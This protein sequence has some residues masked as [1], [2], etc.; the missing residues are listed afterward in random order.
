MTRAE[1]QQRFHA[2]KAL[3]WQFTHEMIL[4]TLPEA[5]V[6]YYT[7]SRGPIPSSDL[8]WDERVYERDARYAQ[9]QLHGP[10]SETAYLNEVWREEYVPRWI[11][12]CVNTFET[13]LL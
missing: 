7:M 13:T 8:G 5:V 1:F 12:V 10:F 11:A 4:E 9:E 2:A 6:Y 3:L